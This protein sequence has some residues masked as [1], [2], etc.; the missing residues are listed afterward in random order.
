M[1]ETLSW[2]AYRYALGF[3]REIGCDKKV[4]PVLDNDDD[5]AKAQ[6]LGEDGAVQMI[7]GGSPVRPSRRQEKLIQHGSTMLSPRRLR[8]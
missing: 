7:F 5:D 3:L 8:T 2:H 6:Y 4:A 1:H